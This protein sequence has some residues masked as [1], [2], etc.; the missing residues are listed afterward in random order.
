MQF[1]PERQQIGRNFQH[2]LS[3]YK[4]YQRVVLPIQFRNLDHNK[5]DMCMVLILFFATV[6]LVIMA[7]AHLSRL[8]NY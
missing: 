7:E 8:G 6:V 1:V 5:S 3:L 2:L 4:R